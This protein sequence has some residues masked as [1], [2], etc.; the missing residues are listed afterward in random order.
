MNIRQLQLL[1]QVVECNLN[2]SRAARAAHTTQPSVSRHLQALET[3]LG[4]QLFVRSKRKISGL[5][6][7]GRQVLDSARHVLHELDTLS[8]LGKKNTRDQQ[9]SITIAA[10]HTYARYSL[11]PVVRTFMERYP[12]VRLVLRQGDPQQIMNW[13]STG[14][15]DL[16][17]CAE[18]NERPKALA[19]FSCNRHERVILTSAG[20]ALTKIKRPTLEQLG[21]HRLITYDS[22]FAIHRKIMEAFESKGLSPNIVLTATDVDVM[23]TY[24]KGGLGVAIVASLAYSRT[25]D[26]GLR[27]ISANHLF[28]PTTIKLGVRKGAFLRSFVYDFI[29]MFSP[30]LPREHVQ[31]ALFAQ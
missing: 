13:A 31:R 21:R 20:H 6:S 4:V 1:S 26:P 23:K 5:T 12:K 18:P 10:S 27:A 17:I 25:E 8:Q 14:E 16:A 15:A 11:P 7:T 29:E 9:G 3:Q 28:E 19:F 22:Q 30:A 24:V 2:I